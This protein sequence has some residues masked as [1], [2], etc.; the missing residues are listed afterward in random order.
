MD[1]LDALKTRSMR[2]VCCNFPELHND[3]PGLAN[4]GFLIAPWGRF[5]AILA[6]ECANERGDWANFLGRLAIYKKYDDYR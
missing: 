2:G 6:T 5:R 1:F 3:T 4:V